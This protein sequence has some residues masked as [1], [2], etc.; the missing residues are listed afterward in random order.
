MSDDRK[1]AKQAKRNKRK[2][3]QRRQLPARETEQPELQMPR[4]TLRSQGRSVVW[5]DSRGELAKQ[6]DIVRA[7]EQLGADLYSYGT[8]LPNAESNDPDTE[9]LAI[10]QQVDMALIRFMRGAGFHA[11]LQVGVQ[12][13]L[14]A[15]N[16]RALGGGFPKPIK[17]GRAVT[18]AVI[19]E[20]RIACVALMD[21]L[22]SDDNSRSMT[23]ARDIAAREV[24]KRLRE[25][26]APALL[27]DVPE[28]AAEQRRW[29]RAETIVGWRA[30]LARLP[31]DS[32]SKTQWKELARMPGPANLVEER[33]L[34]A[35]T[36]GL[37]DRMDM[38]KKLA[39]LLDGSREDQPVVLTMD[40]P[41]S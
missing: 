9:Q 2:Q 18:P 12:T 25:V 5:V 40:R 27:Y 17:E 38:E 20:R 21:R 1:A 28:S 19:W 31:N 7:A 41:R 32:A 29:V 35:A 11:S 36:L 14:A 26:G 24:A 34:F 23:T 39:P 30:E 33:L 8:Q 37:S 15:L 16:R 4:P 13:R 6:L 22:R 10:W 3:Q